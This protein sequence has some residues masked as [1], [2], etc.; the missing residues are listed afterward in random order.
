MAAGSTRDFPAQDARLGAHDATIGIDADLFERGKIDDKAVGTAPRQ[1]AMAART[2]RDFEFVMPRKLNRT[3]HIVLVPALNDGRRYP[4]RP[5]VPVEHPPGALIGGITRQDETA[6]QLR[7]KPLKRVGT[8]LFLL[9]R[10]EPP[11]TRRVSEAARES[12]GP[13]DE[14]ASSGSFALGV[15]IN[16][17]RAS[18]IGSPGAGPRAAQPVATLPLPLPPG[19]PLAAPLERRRGRVPVPGHRLE[20]GR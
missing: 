12:G 6:L 18:R 10:K 9:C 2:D 13:F 19:R 3:H 5:R 20:P 14:V 17:A 8:N 11:A 16:R 15:A 4:L 1:M 7:A